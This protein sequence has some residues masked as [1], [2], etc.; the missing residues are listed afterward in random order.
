MRARRVLLHPAQRPKLWYMIFQTPNPYYSTTKDISDPTSWEVPKVMLPIID[1]L[2]DS[3]KRSQR[4]ENWIDYFHICGR[5]HCHLFYS[6]DVR[7]W[8]RHESL[9]EQFPLG[10]SKAYHIWNASKPGDWYEGSAVCKIKGEGRYLA[11]S[12][13][14]TDGWIRYYKA[15]VADSLRGS[16]TPYPNSSFATPFAGPASTKFKKNTAWVSGVE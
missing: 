13:A 16:F 1:P 10:W 2:V 7:D 5:T 14:A 6:N 3:E 9:R 8:F 4:W 12:E 15:M 11:I